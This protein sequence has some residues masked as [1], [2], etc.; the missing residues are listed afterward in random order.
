MRG[1]VDRKI[2]PTV[3]S[4]SSP[5]TT[6]M[7]MDLKEQMPRGPGDATSWKGQ[8]TPKQRAVET[9]HVHM[10]DVETRHV[11]MCVLCLA[12]RPK[13]ECHE[14]ADSQTNSDSHGKEWRVQGV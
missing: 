7:A 13:L 3:N 6:N 12:G 14:E 4:D 10:C 8:V 11:H 1:A 2:C 9:R 5:T